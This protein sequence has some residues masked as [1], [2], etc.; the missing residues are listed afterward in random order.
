MMAQA[1]GQSS[2]GP[3]AIEKQQEVLSRLHLHLTHHK[4]GP[5]AAFQAMREVL[6]ELVAADAI[7]KGAIDTALYLTAARSLC[8]EES[9]PVSRPRGVPQFVSPERFHSQRDDDW[10]ENVGQN[11]GRPSLDGVV[12]LAAT[13]QCHRRRFKDTWTI[14][15]YSG[16]ATMDCDDL[17]SQLRQL[18]KVLALG[19]VRVLYDAPAEG[20]V[21]HP[22][23]DIAGAI[24]PYTVVLCPLIARLVGWEPD[25]SHAFR[26]VD[27]SGEIVA[28]TLIWRDG[29]ILTD[30]HDFGGFA[31]GSVLVVRKREIERL[32]PFISRPQ[33]SIAWRIT[34]SEEEGRIVNQVGVDDW[35]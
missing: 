17:H 30:Q 28:D 22:R 2:F 20:A 27:S 31:G 23:A 8:I 4:L 12:V 33:R 19:E 32:R 15:S 35:P 34:Q 11:V 9:S 29:G 16:P 3:E 6:G 13:A 18:P 7:D 21:T 5:A 24:D 10:R 14:Q 1:G 26:Y 25:P